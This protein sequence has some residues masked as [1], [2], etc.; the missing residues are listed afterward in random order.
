MSDIYNKRKIISISIKNLNDNKNN[1]QQK[2]ICN[3]Y[4]DF[5]KNNDKIL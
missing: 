4:S 2:S 3:Y 1:L 5:T